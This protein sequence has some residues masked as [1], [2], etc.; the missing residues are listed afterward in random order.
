MKSGVE[1]QAYS[2]LDP[3]Q[4]N[5]CQR[6]GCK[7]AK[8]MNLVNGNPI[9]CMVRLTAEQQTG[10]G[11]DNPFVDLPKDPMK[12][13]QVL[14]QATEEADKQVLHLVTQ[15]YGRNIPTGCSQQ[16]DLLRDS[17]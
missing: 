6:L 1:Q 13:I 7:L 3:A 11:V 4:L 8:P 14:K 15:H 17:S 16:F 2:I 5:I 12:A 9:G 10:L